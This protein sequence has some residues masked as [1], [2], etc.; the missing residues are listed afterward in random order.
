MLVSG[1]S[2]TLMVASLAVAATL[3]VLYVPT[4]GQAEPSA[5]EATESTEP[6]TKPPK[7]D[8]TPADVPHGRFPS[9]EDQKLADMA[10]KR[11][12]LELEPIGDDDLKRVKDLGYDGGV[13][14]AH[15]T[16]IEKQSIL[17]GD[18]LVGLHVWPTTSVKEV[19]DVLKRD[20]LAELNPL[21]F[22]V[23]RQD[24]VRNIPG[25][26]ISIDKEMV[27]DRV[28]TGRYT[29]YIGGGGGTFGSRMSMGPQPKPNRNAATN[30]DAPPDKSNLRYDGKSFDEWRG[31]WKTELSTEKRLEAVKALAAFGRAGYGKEA[32]EAILDVAGEYD[33]TNEHNDSSDDPLRTVVYESLR[34]KVPAKE[35]Q[36]LLRARLR[37]RPRE[38][39]VV[40]DHGAAGGTHRQR[41]ERQRKLELSSATGQSSG[42]HIVVQSCGQ[43]RPALS[44]QARNNELAQGE[45]EG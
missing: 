17:T 41:T 5:T 25:T 32:T 18:I 44:G 28:V 9:L 34:T 33:F 7:S 20:D 16:N 29:L 15:T 13:K 21:K 27:R 6:K 2:F 23:V 1:K 3:A 14:V 24:V 31:V 40:R 36:P 11:L 26:S 43:P 12:N 38:V 39:E 8:H 45:V 19:I 22:Y 37:K 4:I 30:T 35:W 10:W 42:R